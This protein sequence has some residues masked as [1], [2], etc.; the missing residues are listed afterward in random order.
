MEHHAVRSRPSTLTR[1][2]GSAKDVL[3]WIDHDHFAAR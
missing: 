2:T 1:Q 3:P